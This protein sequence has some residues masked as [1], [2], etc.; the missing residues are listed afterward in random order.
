[1]LSNRQVALNATNSDKLER[2]R[3]AM[4]QV[5]DSI[6]DLGAMSQ[7]SNHSTCQA[8]KEIGDKAGDLFGSSTEQSKTLNAIFE[9]LKQ[10]TPVKSQQT[11]AEAVSHE[12]TEIDDDVEME[13][14]SH[15][16]LDDDGLQDAI[17]RLRYLAK[18]EKKTIISDEAI[19]M[20]RDVNKIFAL[21][22]KAE[23]DGKSVK[24]RGNKRGRESNANYPKH[25]RDLEYRHEVNRIKGLLTTSHCVAINEKGI[26]NML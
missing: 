23:G 18:E 25:D 3:A 14:R 24:H 12:A 1:M 22:L 26:I 5:C 9:L 13:G 7:V 11:S 15:E 4:D 21:P 10:Q 17:N 20:I 16:S 6:Q 2:T 19:A 8:L